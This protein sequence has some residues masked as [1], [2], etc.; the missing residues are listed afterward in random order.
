[1]KGSVGRSGGA[2]ARFVGI[3]CFRLAPSLVEIVRVSPLLQLP[4]GL[5]VDR[6]ARL[7][8]G[9]TSYLGR[10][11]LPGPLLDQ[12]RRAAPEPRRMPDPDPRRLPVDRHL[13]W[14]DP[15]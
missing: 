12:Q 14:P 9:A 3:R 13:V 5:A 6:A 2:T 10:G 8:R 4:V 1:M 7:V 15:F 11:R